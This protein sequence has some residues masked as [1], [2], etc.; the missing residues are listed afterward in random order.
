MNNNFGFFMPLPSFISMYQQLIAAPSISAI[1]DNLCMS[2]KN[3]IELLAN[4]C[5]ILGFTCEIIEL[6]GG[7]G[8]I[9]Y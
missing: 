7:K 8:A 2:N 5:E 1:E 9:I 4:W 3:V 6:K